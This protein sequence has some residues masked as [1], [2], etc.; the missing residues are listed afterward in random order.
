MLYKLKLDEVDSNSTSPPLVE[1]TSLTK[2]K[3][4]ILGKTQREQVKQAVL[5]NVLAYLRSVAKVN[6]AKGSCKKP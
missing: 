5:P 3:R 2:Q 6:L 4:D 1:A